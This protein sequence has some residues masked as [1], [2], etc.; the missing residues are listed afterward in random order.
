M[1][2]F[3]GQINTTVGALSSNASL[4]HNAY[5]QGVKA[6]ADVVMVPELAVTGYPPLDLLD[7][8]VFIS[9][10]LETRDALAKATGKTALIF[11]CITR[12]EAWC[13][14]PLH[15]TAVV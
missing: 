12:S 1:K 2:I 5:E 15:N 7:R 9:A 10:A 4:I 6:G 3:L 8:D 13:G 11:G 14:K